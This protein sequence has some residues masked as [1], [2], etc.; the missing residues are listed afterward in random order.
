[1]KEF[2]SIRIVD[3]GGDS[4][5]FE[6]TGNVAGSPYDTIVFLLRATSGL[7]AASAKDSADPQKV[8]DV[9]AKVFAKYVAKDIRDGRVH[10]AEDGKEDAEREQE[11]ENKP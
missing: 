1:M 3:K 5:S 7:I 11:R 2:D 8:A 6:M 4:I 9:F 10:Q